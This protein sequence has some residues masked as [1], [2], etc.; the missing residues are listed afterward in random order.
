MPTDADARRSPEQAARKERDGPL[1]YTR[2]D[3]SPSH[4]LG[5]VGVLEPVDAVPGVG[6][7]EVGDL[8]GGVELEHEARYLSHTMPATA[9]GRSV[10]S[11][12]E[13]IATRKSEGAKGMV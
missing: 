3:R 10:R 11:R 7:V 12:I 4:D 2:S 1:K 6:L 8:T 5:G 9:Q 13:M